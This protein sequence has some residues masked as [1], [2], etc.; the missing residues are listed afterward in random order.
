MFQTLEELEEACCELDLELYPLLWEETAEYQLVLE[1]YRIH[2]PQLDVDIYP[3]LWLNYQEDEKDFVL[4]YD[5]FLF[6]PTGSNEYIYSEGYSS[7]YSAVNNF[8]HT[9]K[10]DVNVNDLTYELITATAVN[11]PIL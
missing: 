5:M 6:F 10:T 1:G 4:D 11:A 7:L 9:L 2:I 8:L 3:S